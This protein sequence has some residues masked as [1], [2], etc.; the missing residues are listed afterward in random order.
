MLR[1][2]P[3]STL[4]PY[5]T[6][7]RSNFTHNG[8]ERNIETGVQI[9]DERFAR[10]LAGHWRA[11]IGAGLLRRFDLAPSD[12]EAA[13]LDVVLEQWNDL[14]DWVDPEYLPLFDELKTRGLPPPTDA[15]YELTWRGRVSD[16]VAV[17]YWDND[18]APVG[19]CREGVQA[20]N[21][22]VVQANPDAVAEAVAA[23]LQRRWAG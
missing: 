23:E 1:R 17:L 7:F 18:G 10:E 22:S 5:T 14:R 8:Q 3:R 16:G 21:L 2:P 12:T 20:D 4:F 19:L 11:L 6:L 9:D 13:A 15:D